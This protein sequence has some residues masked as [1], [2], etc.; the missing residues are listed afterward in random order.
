MAAS[1]TV[2]PPKEAG[3]AVGGSEHD[4]HVLTRLDGCVPDG[5]VLERHPRV[6]L[7]GGVVAQEFLCLGTRQ[8]RERVIGG[9][10]ASFVGQV[11]VVRGEVVR[12]PVDLRG[13]EGDE[14]VQ[15]ATQGRRCLGD[16]GPS[17]LDGDRRRRRGSRRP[18]A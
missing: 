10:L 16:P 7:D 4:R 12:R 9:S 8:Y 5:H 11:A 13:V 2:K 18:L 3:I 6:S 14:R 17:F 1:S 15:D